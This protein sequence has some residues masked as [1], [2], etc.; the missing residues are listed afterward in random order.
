MPHIS[1]PHFYA[2]HLFELIFISGGNINSL[3]TTTLNE[4]IEL[5][6][7]GRSP[8]HP[9]S[10]GSHLVAS[11]LAK[12]LQES[13][14][15]ASNRNSSPLLPV[16]GYMSALE[17]VGNCYSLVNRNSNYTNGIKRCLDLFAG[18]PKKDIDTLY[19]LRN[20]IVHN[21]SVMHI[22]SGQGVESRP[23][24]LT[25]FPANQDQKKGATK[26]IVSSSDVPWDGKAA[27]L[28]LAHFSSISIQGLA[29]LANNTIRKALEEFKNANLVVNRNYTKTS[30][31]EEDKDYILV[32][33]LYVIDAA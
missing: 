13:N 2:D 10:I 21:A 22:D 30:S 7:N 14:S 1:G 18:L 15:A 24:F 3:S 26:A 9:H 27:T 5:H 28:T 29:H 6:L 19:G 32:R 17:Q 23:Y 12:I 8:I 20:A 4:I 31:D 25:G 11:A 33:Y 16:M